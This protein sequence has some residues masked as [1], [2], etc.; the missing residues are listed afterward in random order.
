MNDAI[1]KAAEFFGLGNKQA[2]K[3]RVKAQR[4]AA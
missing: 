2:V 1:N 3:A 4:K